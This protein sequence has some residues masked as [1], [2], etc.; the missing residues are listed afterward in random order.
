MNKAKKKERANTPKE[1]K[2]LCKKL[3]FNVEMLK[4][5]VAAVGCKIINS[6]QDA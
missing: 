4:S 1:V 3:G 5:S 2:R 6:E